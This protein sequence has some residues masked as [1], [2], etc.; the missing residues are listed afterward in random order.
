MISGENY[1]LRERKKAGI[2]LP[3]AKSVTKVGQS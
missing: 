1:R 2:K 3:A